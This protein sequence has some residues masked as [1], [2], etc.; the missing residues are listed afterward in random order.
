MK[1][2]DIVFVAAMGPPGGGRSALTARFQRHF[3]FLTYT[4]LGRDSMSMIFDKIV[5]AFIGR[6]SDEV[7]SA[8]AQIVESSQNLFENV[9]NTL[10]PT[11]SK[12]HY[13]FNMRDIS[14]V[15]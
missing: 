12:S 1:I 8:I 15:M 9:A 4:N 6:F 10:R 13:T 3:N 14:K 11:P 5:R 2:E 7:G